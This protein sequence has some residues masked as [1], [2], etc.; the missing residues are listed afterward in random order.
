MWKREL[1]RALGPIV[2]RARPRRVD[3]PLHRWGLERDERGH[4]RVRGVDIRALVEAYGSPLH[5]LDAGALA[6]NAAHFTSDPRCEVFYSYKTNPVRAVLERLHAAGVGAEVISPYELWLARRLGVDPK[7]VVFNGPAKTE[8]ALRDA[9]ESGIELINVNA[10]EEIDLIAGVAG[11]LGKRARVGVRV[12]VPGGWG[13]QF[14][15]SIA[16]G[17]AMQA[18]RAAKQRP[19]LDVVGVHAHIGAEISTKDALV[20]LIDR[21]LDFVD[22]VRSELG[23]ALSILDLGG[24][25]ACPSVARIDPLDLR[26]NRVFGC[27][28]VP[29]E[30]SSVLSIGAY[31]RAIGDAVEAHFDALGVPRPRVFLE[32]GRA[33]TGDTQLLVCS[34]LAV[35]APED[36]VSYAVLDAGINVAE[37]VRNEFHQLFHAGPERGERRTYRLAGPICTPMDVLYGAWD[38]PELREGDALV[39]A[40]SGAYFVP[41]STSFSFPRPAIVAIE[42]GQPRLVRRRERFEDLARFDLTHDA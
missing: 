33:M 36:G 25:L 12:V 15:E 32:P 23:L 22:D 10:R 24:S 6:R 16:S 5:V 42:D 27:D 9:I 1:R 37:P 19:E 17:A 39:I 8:G 31:V 41:F 26:L 2:R 4:L 29:R 21:V 30:P 20:S 7:R 3:L 13:G 40:D 14:G 34:V 18:V 35:R 28:L 38:L 11:K